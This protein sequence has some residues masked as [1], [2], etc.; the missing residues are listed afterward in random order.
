MCA[1]LPYTKREFA[2]ELKFEL[3]VHKCLERVLGRMVKR[4]NCVK[5]ELEHLSIAVIDICYQNAHISKEREQP[6]EPSEGRVLTQCKE[7]PIKF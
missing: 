4:I 7:L 2:I 3:K 6:M 5:H 1:L